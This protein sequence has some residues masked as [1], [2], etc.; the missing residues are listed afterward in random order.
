MPALRISVGL[1]VN[2]RIQGLSASSRME[3]RS[4]PSAKIFT[5]NEAISG[6]AHCSRGS[7]PTSGPQNPERGFAQRADLHER[8]VRTLF[9]VAVVDENGAAAG[10]MAGFDV[11]PAVA[12]D[13]AGFKID[14][15]DPGGFEQQAGLGF[16]AGAAGGVVVRAE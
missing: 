8:P 10:A 13:V 5:R 1:V 7:A 11:A 16:S 12:N 3:A 14:V 6:I 9:G 15:P 4:A 2:P